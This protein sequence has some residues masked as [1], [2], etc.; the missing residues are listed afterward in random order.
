MTGNPL[1]ESDRAGVSYRAVATIFVHKAALDL[2][3]PQEA[4]AK[5]ISINSGAVSASHG[6]PAAHPAWHRWH[7]FTG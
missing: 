7:H 5:R 6:T 1:I 3:S 4:I 2:P